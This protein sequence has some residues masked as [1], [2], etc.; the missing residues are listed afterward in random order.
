M[1]WF[2]NIRNT[3]GE[4]KLATRLKVHS[5]AT[6]MRNLYDAQHIGIIYNASDGVSFDIIKDLV[7][8]LSRDEVKVSV[9][10]FVNSKKLPEDYLYRTGFDFFSKIDLNW[11][12]KPVSL[13]VD[14]F[15]QEEFDLLIDL[16]LDDHYPIRYIT[17]LS[18]AHYKAGRYSEN[19][20]HLD[21]MIDIEKEKQALKEGH[22]NKNTDEIGHKT[23]NRNNESGI[24]QHKETEKQ[25]KFLA[26][27]LL[28]YLSI[29]K[30]NSAWK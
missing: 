14:Q 30:V 4:R 16:S 20:S 3:V 13:V 2:S 25:L 26:D 17:A 28:H 11:Y 18:H 15:M 27:Q 8:R 24:E 12:S 23:E 6:V 21:F 19:E 22:I 5:R 7:K 10:G 9:L 29:I 1:N